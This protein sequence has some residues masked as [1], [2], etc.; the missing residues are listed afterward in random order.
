MQQGQRSHAQQ[1]PQHAQ[2]AQQPQHARRTKHAHL[3]LL[4]RPR[5]AAV[6]SE[7]LGVHPNRFLVSSQ[8]ILDLQ[9]VEVSDI[10][11]AEST[12]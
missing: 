5:L 9:I 12:P 11:S 10:K 6:R 3:H 7:Q 1:Q 4:P 2:H 8:A